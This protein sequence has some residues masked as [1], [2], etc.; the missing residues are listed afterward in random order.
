LK[1]LPAFIAGIV[2][3]LLLAGGALFWAIS[4]IDGI[5]NYRSP[6]HD[7]PPQS[8]T[9]LGQPAT[10]QVVFVLIDA[11]RLDTSLDKT[12]MPTLNQL[13]QQGASAQMHSR[14]PSY[15]EPGYSCLFTGAWPDL[16]DG[17]AVNLDYEEIPTWTQDNL[18]SAAARSGLKT[19][20]SGYYW[21]EKL[22]PQSAVTTSF[23]T[24]GE[25]QVADRQ[26]VD[27][28][29]PWIASGQY[30]LTLIH[31]DQVDYAGHHEGGPRDPRWNQAASRADALLSEI[32]SK[33]D[34]SK[35]TVL[36][37][38]DHGQIDAGG[39]GG[40][41]PVTLLEPFV[42]AGAG[43]KPG[44][45]GDV[46]MVDV[47]PTLAS[48]LGTNLPASTQG[49]VLAKMLNLP[50]S[51]TAALPGAVIAQQTQ[52]LT[53]YGRA[54]GVTVTVP[55]GSVV[56]AYQAEI[57]SAQDA[58]ANA[59]RLPRGI[60]SAVIIALPLFLILRHRRRTVLWFLAGAL[61]YI[62]LFN[63]GYAVLE[64]KTYSLSSVT[65]QTDLILTIVITAGV[66]LL[67][68]WI[69]CAVGSGMFR[70]S[71][72]PAARAAQGLFSITIYLLLIPVL[73]HFTWNGA[74]PTWILPEFWSAFIALLSMIQIMIVS[75]LGMILMGLTS[76][77]ASLARRFSQL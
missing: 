45:Y 40:P 38:S 56:A 29:L 26:V 36:V 35:D 72:L 5:Y 27:A 41:E 69:V 6:L 30:Q 15:S 13:R 75:I 2:I 12:V 11:L 42:L 32:L 33:L 3:F 10:R 25:D 65:G 73:V 39:H 63:L 60:L 76:V 43:V 22:V 4:L 17:P 52:L 14:P 51:T 23:Y 62:A 9:A 50:A 64:G 59:A 34:L 48:L 54:I 71:P 44:S 7:N 31:I 70:Q 68:A 1:R 8:G 21:F 61:I 53:G 67:I 19:A 74:V 77:I 16:S 20:I 28:A 66:S 37:V 46:Q 57:E 55:K 18:F 24:P 47:A 49:Q 58:R